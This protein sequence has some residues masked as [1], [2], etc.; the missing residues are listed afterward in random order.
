LKY[1][2]IEAAAARG[3]NVDEALGAEKKPQVKKKR[4]RRP[5]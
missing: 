3:E 5:C 4:R 2:E 1:A